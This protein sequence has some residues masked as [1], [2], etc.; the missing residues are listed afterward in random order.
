MEKKDVLHTPVNDSLAVQEMDCRR[1]LTSG[2]LCKVCTK[3]T[4]AGGSS[5]TLQHGAYAGARQ[6]RNETGV[7][8]VGPLDREMVVDE[9][10]RCGA[11]QDGPQRSRHG[12][13]GDLVGCSCRGICPHRFDGYEAAA[14]SVQVA[15]EP[16]SRES[17]KAKLV[18][19]GIPTIVENVVD[20][21]GM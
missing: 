4:T 19:D 11:G 1:S 21:Y 7:R 20:G 18:E 16:D 17:A 15:R 8:P 9:V 10:D 12:Y 5:K 13:L 3:T 6:R 14:T 2:F